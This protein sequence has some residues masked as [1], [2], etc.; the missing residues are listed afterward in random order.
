MYF[1]RE[2]L[3]CM[4]QYEYMRDF[5]H[6]PPFLTSSRSSYFF[7]LLLFLFSFFFCWRQQYNT[8]RAILYP[9]KHKTIWISRYTTKKHHT[10]QLHFAVKITYFSQISRIKP[11]KLDVERNKKWEIRNFKILWEHRNNVI[12][13]HACYKIRYNKDSIQQI[14]FRKIRSINR[15]MG[16]KKY[17]KV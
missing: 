3:Q 8:L 13:Q 10:I 12:N 15:R 6:A 9:K 16:F 1:C 7:L 17:E 4:F 11:Y 5:P 2:R 14:V